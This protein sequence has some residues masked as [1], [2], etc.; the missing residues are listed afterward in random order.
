M[1]LKNKNE[2]EMQD[3]TQNTETKSE[4]VISKDITQ[5]WTKNCPKCGREQV[6]TSKYT[7][8]NAILE[9]KWCNTCRGDKRKV[10]VPVGGWRK[11]CPKCGIEQTY[12]CKSI[13][14]LSLKENRICNSCRSVK[15]R[16]HNGIFERNC[17]CGKVLK[18][19][20]RQGLNHSKKYDS[21]CRNCAAKES[22]KII[23]RSFQKTDKYREMMSNALKN[24]EKNKNKFTEKFREKLRIAKLNQIRKLGTKYTYN[25]IACKFIDEYGKKHG[26][27]FQ[28]AM[29][30]GEKII[31]GYSLDGYDENKNV[32]FEYDEPKHNCL[33]VKKNDKIR[34]QRIIEKIK[35]V[36]FIRYNEEFNKL[37]DVVSGKEIL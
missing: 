27:N 1:N 23:D 16:I 29:N 37:C 13:Y 18:Y 31:A 33:S 9:N 2:L 20:C 12:S 11:T 17:K 14:I 22:A 34:E 35:P 6:Y 28:H 32:V 24:S 3:I 30:G 7:L 26:Y 15:R 8:K 21:I 19:N 10:I 5:K 4:N 25:P 36:M